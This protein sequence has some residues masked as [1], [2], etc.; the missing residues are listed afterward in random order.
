MFTVHIEIKPSAEAQELQD[1][2][3]AHHRAWF[4][5]H[6]EAGDFLLV[7]PSKDKAGTGFVLAQAESREA[8]DSIIA[9]DAY[10]PDGATY[11]IQEIAAKMVADNIAHYKE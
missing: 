10:Y 2:R 1:E 11:L 3:L 5:R 8:L 7:G 4:T 9:Q 6:F